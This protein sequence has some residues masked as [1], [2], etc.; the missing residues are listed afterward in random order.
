MNESENHTVV[1]LELVALD[2]DIKYTVLILLNE[3]DAAFNFVVVVFDDVKFDLAF[4]IL[5]KYYYLILC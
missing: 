3:D 5:L 4:F 1:S 2:I